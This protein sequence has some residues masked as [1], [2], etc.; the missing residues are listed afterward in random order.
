MKALAE[1]LALVA[2]SLGVGVLVAFAAYM[3]FL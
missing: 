2:V 3:L 1:L